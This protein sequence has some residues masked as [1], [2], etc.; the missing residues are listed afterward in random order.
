MAK[1]DG[2]VAQ[3]LWW[4]DTSC[5]AYDRS[6]SLQD[7]Q[8]T[9]EKRKKTLNITVL[10]TL[11]RDSPDDP[12]YPIS[13]HLLKFLQPFNS[14]TL[15]LGGIPDLTHSIC[16]F[17]GQTRILLYLLKNTYYVTTNMTGLYIFHT[18]FWTDL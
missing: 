7:S 18:C 8:R 14:T 9:K 15:D 12:K 13:T 11:Q 4:D 17:G 10:H 5:G 6:C 3:G 1:L 2:L 16:G